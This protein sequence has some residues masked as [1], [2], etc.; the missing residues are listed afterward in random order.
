MGFHA[1]EIPGRDENI[2]TRKER[3]G[4]NEIAVILTKEF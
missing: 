2:E 3:K 4:A 1:R